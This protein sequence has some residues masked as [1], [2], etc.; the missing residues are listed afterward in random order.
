M[1]SMLPPS[2]L[3]CTFGGR[4]AAGP[5]LEEAAGDLVADLNARDA[6]ADLH[7]HAACESRPFDAEH[8]TA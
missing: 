5:A 6:G 7:H 8:R 1:P 2:A 3:A 4:F